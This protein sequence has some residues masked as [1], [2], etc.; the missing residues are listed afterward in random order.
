MEIGLNTTVFKHKN[1][2]HKM[3]REDFRRQD[4][5]HGNTHD[6][7]YTY[8]YIVIANLRLSLFRFIHIKPMKNNCIYDKI[9][10]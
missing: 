8:I 1:K 3:L 2:L 5:I 6:I 7:I 4:K 10:K 9:Y